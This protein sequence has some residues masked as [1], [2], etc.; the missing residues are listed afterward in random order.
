L[1]PLDG[2]K[3]RS[4]FS[5]KP[6]PQYEGMALA[7]SSAN[8]ID[9]AGF[10]YFHSSADRNRSIVKDPDL[11]K[12]LDAIRSASSEAQ[13]L[14]LT[15]DLQIRFADQMYSIPLPQLPY[16]LAVNPK[17]KDVYWKN[18]GTSTSGSFLRSAWFDN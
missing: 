13:L 14:K 10:S 12:I 18:T 7:V 9:E 17:V 1:D 11:D 8:T 2:G 6:H 4:S 3:Y 15:R 16:S 5:G